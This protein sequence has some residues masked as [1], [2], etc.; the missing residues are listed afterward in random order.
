[1]TQGF[2]A[3]GLRRRDFFKVLA[4]GG[5][6]AVAAG[7]SDKPEKLIPLLV[8]PDNIEYVPGIPVEYAT[9]CAECAAGCGMIMKTR[10]GRAIKA[11]GNPDHPVNLGALCVRGQASLQTALYN[12][13][14]L[15]GAMLRQGDD[16][17]PAE[18]AAAEAA[19][20]ER[21]QARSAKHT[22]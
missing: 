4:A 18:W 19:A 1:M 6:S 20:P 7:C 22:P 17:Q 14:R 9:T 5:A 2:M 15:R 21:P 13:S 11:E 16:W 10:E 8:P 3:Q 12:P